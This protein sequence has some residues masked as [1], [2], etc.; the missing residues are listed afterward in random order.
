MPE[1]RLRGEARNEA[2]RAQLA[3]LEPGERPAPVVAGALVCAG[4][5]VANVVL[6]VAG[7]EIDGGA[8]YLPV[9]AL[10]LG[11]LAVGLWRVQYWAALGFQGV[12]AITAIYAFLSLL[13]AA[14]VAAAALS[15]AIL[16]ASGVM[17]W[18]MVRVLGRI[19]APRPE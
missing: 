14:N 8:A 5:A 16:L 18:T 17:F 6:A 19:Q 2:I 3:P 13:V 10:L 9:F 1:P 4:L 7:R 15:V 12:C 11:G